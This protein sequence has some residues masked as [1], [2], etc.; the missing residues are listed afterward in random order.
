M[1]QLPKDP[2]MLMSFLN[3]KLRGH[4]P[5]LEAL[6]DDYRADPAAL[7]AT[8]KTIGYTYDASQNQFKQD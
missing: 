5:S 6:C 4:Y 1:Y 2:M 7:I 8:L 3:E